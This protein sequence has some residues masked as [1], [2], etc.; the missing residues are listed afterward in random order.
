[1]ATCEEED[2]NQ[3]DRSPYVTI[4]NQWCYEWPSNAYK[5]DGAKKDGSE[6]YVEHIVDWSTNFGVR[7]VGKMASDPGMY[8]LRGLRSR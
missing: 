6:N 4:L 2:H 1:M 3:A 7:V 5:T 8:L